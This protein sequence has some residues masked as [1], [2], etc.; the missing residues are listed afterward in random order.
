MI[1]YGPYRDMS[2]KLLSMISQ[3]DMNTIKHSKF[4]KSPN[5]VRKIQK[6]ADVIKE[7]PLYRHGV[8]GM[9]FEDNLY[10]IRRWIHQVPKIDKDGK[11]NPCVIIYDYLKLNN[12]RQLSDFVKENQ[13]LGYQL[14]ALQNLGLQ[15]SVPIVVFTQLNRDGI[16][17]ETSDII[18]GSDRLSWFATSISIFK[19]KSA[20]EIAKDGVAMGN[21]KI[22]SIMCRYGPGHD[23][24]EYVH[25]MMNKKTA[26]IVEASPNTDFVVEGE[27]ENDGDENY[28]E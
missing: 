20:E 22:V 27:L 5:L 18:S 26:T 9:S 2:I 8:S 16:T 13:L 24:G 3:I 1:E 25:I 21:K 12:E 15:Y 4:T 19:D 7:L 10:S 14:T 28:D 11:A 17:K 6:A 23:F